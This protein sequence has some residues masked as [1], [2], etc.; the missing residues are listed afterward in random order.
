MGSGLGMSAP[1]PI[2]DCRLEGPAGMGL[3]TMAIV[4]ES[5]FGHV[6]GS[7]VFYNTAKIELQ[8]IL[9][10]VVTPSVE[11]T[12]SRLWCGHARAQMQ[13]EAE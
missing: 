1:F 10:S 7:D 12:Y 6:F 11:K 13:L 9:I 3:F 4:G 5:P 8:P 2:S